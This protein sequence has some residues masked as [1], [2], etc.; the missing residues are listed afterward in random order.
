ML[1]DFYSIVSSTMT[2]TRYSHNGCKE[3]KDEAI[4]QFP[5][6]GSRDMYSTSSN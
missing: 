3:P 4:L 5:V 1:L 2:G 6:D